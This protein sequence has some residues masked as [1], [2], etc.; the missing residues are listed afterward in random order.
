MVC[1][2]VNTRLL[3]QC[4]IYVAVLLFTCCCCSLVALPHTASRISKGPLFAF[5]LD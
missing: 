3:L 1:E 5:N 2:R 4:K